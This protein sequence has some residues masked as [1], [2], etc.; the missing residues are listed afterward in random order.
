ANVGHNNKFY[1]AR[2]QISSLQ[3]VSFIYEKF[4]DMAGGHADLVYE[5]DPK[6]PIE[7]IYEI[8][9]AHN[10]K[11][12]R[13]SRLR[14]PIVL[15]EILLTA[16]VVRAVG[17]KTKLKEG[18]LNHSFAMA[19]RMVSVPERLIEP[20]LVEGRRTTAVEIPFDRDQVKR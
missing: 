12:Y 2:I 13:L 19:Y 3:K 6:K 10:S 4:T 8:K 1:V 7:L 18:G 20:V 17:D 9:D 11:G 5:V 16:E 15:G 14:N